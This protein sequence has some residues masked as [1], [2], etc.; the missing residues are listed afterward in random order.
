M[1]EIIHIP[2]GASFIKLS[3]NA[4]ENV[5]FFDCDKSISLKNFCDNF[6]KISQ[7]DIAYLYFLTTSYRFNST[8]CT[9]Y[10]IFSYSVSKNK[11]I[12]SYRIDNI[13]KSEKKVLDILATLTENAVAP[14][15]IEYVLDDDTHKRAIISKKETA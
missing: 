7:S 4:K 10:G 2:Y 8:F 1:K 15:H 13:S 12:S 14:S 6:R 11:F 9:T 3:K 5:L